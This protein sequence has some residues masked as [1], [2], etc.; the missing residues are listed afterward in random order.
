MGLAETK[1]W[2]RMQDL[3]VLGVSPIIIR[4]IKRALRAA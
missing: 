3:D 4:E 1:A 2:V